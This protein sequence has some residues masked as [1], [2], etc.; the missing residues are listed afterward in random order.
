MSG[1]WRG[2]GDD[3]ELQEEVNMWG[4]GGGAWRWRGWL[5]LQLVTE[6]AS[7][8]IPLAA[9]EPGEY[10]VFTFKVAVASSSSAVG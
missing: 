10:V 5:S 6:P 4:E 9:N 8:S 1:C 7:L 3:I 2:E